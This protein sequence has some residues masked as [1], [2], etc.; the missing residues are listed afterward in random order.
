MI[1]QDRIRPSTT[2]KILILM[3]HDALLV[4]RTPKN[5][6]DWK[7]FSNLGHI[8]Q[9]PLRSSVV[10]I[11]VGPKDIC[12]LPHLSLFIIEGGLKISLRGIDVH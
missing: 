2:V 10:M 11:F 7:I 12:I 5:V 8:L 1:G 9:M 6:S 3:A 4:S